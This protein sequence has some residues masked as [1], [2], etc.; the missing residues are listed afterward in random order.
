MTE[1]EHPDQSESSQAEGGESSQAD[2]EEV[3]P[4][5]SGRVRKPKV[6]KDSVTPSY[7]KKSVDRSKRTNPNEPGIYNIL[8]CFFLHS[9]LWVIGLKVTEVGFEFRDRSSNLS[10]CQITDHIVP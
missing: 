4:R 5:K 10:M 2:E 3:S 6:F 7:V 1:E 8:L 9:T